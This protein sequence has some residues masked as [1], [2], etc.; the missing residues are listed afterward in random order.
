ML[1]NRDFS[2]LVDAG[3]YSDQV[4]VPL[5]EPFVNANGKIQN[6]LLEKFTSAALISSVAGALRANHYHKTD[7]HWG[8]PGSC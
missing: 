7:W 3:R 8:C 1:S 6:L 2:S 4:E 5:D